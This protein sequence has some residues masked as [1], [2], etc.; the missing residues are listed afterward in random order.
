MEVMFQ[1]D[2]ELCAVIEKSFLES[3][4]KYKVQ[5]EKKREWLR[6]QETVTI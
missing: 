6:K 4:S 3:K 1:E 2:L 5:I